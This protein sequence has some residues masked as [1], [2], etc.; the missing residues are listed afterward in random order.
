MP[1]DR[2][3]DLFVN[4][5]TAPEFVLLSSTSSRQPAE[6]PVLVS[7][8]KHLVRLYLLDATTAGVAPTLKTLATGDQIILAGKKGG[9]GTLLFSADDFLEVD[10]ATGKHYEATLDLTPN[11]LEMAFG[12]DAALVVVCEVEVQNSANTGRRS[13]QFSVR[14]NKG[15]YAGEA[16]PAPAEPQYPAAESLALRVPANGTYR[17]KTA[18]DAQYFQL[19]HA[20]TG[21]WH[22]LFIIGDAGAE[23]LALGPAEA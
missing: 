6:R 21:A 9:L 8:D 11:A 23:Q 14:V 18:A 7:G 4:V 10:D 1:W 12:D 13:R 17:I 16:T 2:S 22:T 19:K 20:A 15:V 3:I 5:G